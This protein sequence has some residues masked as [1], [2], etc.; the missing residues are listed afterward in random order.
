VKRIIPGQRQ[1]ELT[2]I[3]FNGQ[4]SDVAVSLNAGRTYTIYLGGKK[5]DPKTISI[6]FNSPNFSVVPNTIRS[7]EYDQISVVSFDVRV[8]P[9]TPKGDYSIA[10]SSAGDKSYI[11]GGLS[12]ESFANT[13]SSTQ[14]FDE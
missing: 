14:F 1:I 5:L 3:G 8:A 11:A 10:V 12:V 13:L 6:S 2:Y 9:R 7:Q 4:L